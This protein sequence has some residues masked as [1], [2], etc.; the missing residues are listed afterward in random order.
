MKISV[1]LFKMVE[2]LLKNVR[3]NAKKAIQP[4]VINM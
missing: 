3:N 4:H 1:A 2:K